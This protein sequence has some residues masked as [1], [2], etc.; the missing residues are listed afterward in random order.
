MNFTQALQLKSKPKIRK[1]LCIATV[2][3]YKLIL[4]CIENKLLPNDTEIIKGL[5]QHWLNL[6]VA[7]HVLG[8]KILIVNP[9]QNLTLV[10]LKK[11]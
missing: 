10:S 7:I 2:N 5:F 3:D 11:T 6:Y 1:I 8:K 4:G 9:K